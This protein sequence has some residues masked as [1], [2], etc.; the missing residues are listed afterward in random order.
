FF[1]FL[2][3]YLSGIAS[4]I[5]RDS[6]LR[7][8]SEA[9]GVSDDVLRRDLESG[10]PSRVFHK[11]AWQETPRT[12]AIGNE[13]FIMVTVAL[14]M[15]LFAELRKHVS[16]DDCEDPDARELY[17]A[18]EECFRND[19]KKLESLLGRL[20]NSDIKGLLLKK[21]ASEEMMTNQAQMVD[22]GIK[23]IRQKS[24]KRRRAMIFQKMSH[25]EQTQDD[26]MM[27]RDLQLEIMNIDEELKKLKGKGVW[28]K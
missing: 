3:P 6:Y 19:E 4:G 7:Q 18:L 17:I 14:N 15:E 10:Q 16:L 21:A 11:P 25:A 20:D 27:I 28:Q 24:L 26:S 22:D 12:A 1:S 2:K 5:R 8:A 23:T 13:L 9:L